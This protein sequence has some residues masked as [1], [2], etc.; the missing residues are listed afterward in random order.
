MNNLLTIAN[1]ACY[2]VLGVNIAGFFNILPEEMAN[3]NEYVHTL[4]TVVSILYLFAIKIPY[5]VT[6]HNIKKEELRKLKKFNDE[7]EK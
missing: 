5:E 1:T 4:V 6:N 7:Q 2:A 3:I